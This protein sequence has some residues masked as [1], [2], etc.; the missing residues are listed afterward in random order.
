MRRSFGI[1]AGIAVHAPFFVVVWYLH[2]FLKGDQPAAS[3]ADWVGL[4]AILQLPSLDRQRVSESLWIDFFL[5]L[6]FVIVHSLLLYPAVRE[7]LTERIGAP[8]Y[9]LFFCAVTTAGLALTMA[10]WQTGSAVWWEVTGTPRTLIGA[11]FYGSWV[12]LFY[13]FFL[14]GI[15]YQTGWTP[16]WHWVRRRPIPSRPFNPRG[17]FRMMRHPSY[18]AFLG[19]VWFTPVMTADRAI[20]TAVWTVYV[21]V[22]SHLKDRRLLHYIGEPYRRYQET[23]PGYPGFWGPL[24]KARAVPAVEPVAELMRV[25]ARS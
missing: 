20:L 1:A 8:F 18:L 2:W 23:V 24:G 6:Q 21:F 3:A 10:C 11:G 12:L 22:G 19:L 16:W 14:N 13:S 5:A 17:I 9:G 15:G 25:R 7:R 4:K